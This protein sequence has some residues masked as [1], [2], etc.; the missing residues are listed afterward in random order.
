MMG[1]YMSIFSCHDGFSGSCVRGALVTAFVMYPNISSL[2]DG[3]AESGD[4]TPSSAAEKPIRDSDEKAS[5]DSE[6][7][8]SITDFA[9]AFRRLG[10]LGA[11]AA[12]FLGDRFRFGDFDRADVGDFDRVRFGDFDRVFFGDFDPVLFGDFEREGVG[13]FDCARLGDFDE[14]EAASFLG[15]PRGRFSVC[16]VL[17]AF[18]A[19]VLDF[20]RPRFPAVGDFGVSDSLVVEFFLGRPLG[21][22][23]ELACAIDDVE[24]DA[25]TAVAPTPTLF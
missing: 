1:S 11:D 16:D 13:D 5:S 9:A 15:L 18:W 12:D 25:C 3:L 17:V 4:V 20:F 19:V 21:R 23:D 8:I 6:S 10:V 24:K 14:F 7:A 2:L 22:G